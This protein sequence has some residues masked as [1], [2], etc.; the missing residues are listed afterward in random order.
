MATSSTDEGWQAA[1]RSGERRQ[2]AAAAGKAVRSFTFNFPLSLSP[3][4][5]VLPP[6]T[7]HLLTSPLFHLHP[8]PSPLTMHLHLAPCTFHL[9]PFTLHL[10]PIPLSRCL[11]GAV[12]DRG[13][14]YLDGAPHEGGVLLMRDVVVV[15]EGGVGDT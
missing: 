15:V 6:F 14:A 4:T 13:A 12:H 10:S 3:F 11:A 5:F 8:H 9:A 7:L 2:Q 1:T